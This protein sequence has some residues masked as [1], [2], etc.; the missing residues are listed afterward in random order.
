MEHLINPSEVSQYGRPIEGKV[1]DS[2]LLAYI[3]EAEHLNVKPVLG[4]KLYLD[5]L[6]EGE[7][8]EKY[9]MLLTGGT[10]TDDESN[11]YTFAGLKTAMAYY[12]FAK[13]VMVGDFQ[14][15]RYGTVLKDGDYSSHISNKERSDCYN[16]T[17]EVANSYL[18][19]CLN[20]CKRVGILTTAPGRPKT[21]GGI[22]IRK[23]GK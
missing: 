8:N 7:T 21:S 23:I 11:I 5:L 2:Q 20:Y 16:D 4:D 19:D 22:K 9:Q 6:K 18:A 14:I 17:L 10:Y 1:K 15:T 12:V 3:S 13:I